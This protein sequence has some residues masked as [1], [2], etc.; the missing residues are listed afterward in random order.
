M[1]RYDDWD[2]FLSEAIFMTYFKIMLCTQSCGNK[3]HVLTHYDGNIQL[4]L[5]YFLVTMKS[6]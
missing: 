6:D 1:A 5:L 3:I 2:V 4:V